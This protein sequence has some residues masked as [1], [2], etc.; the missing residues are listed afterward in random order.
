M[1]RVLPA[2]NQVPAILSET[3]SHLNT[4]ARGSGPVREIKFA[5][6]SLRVLRSAKSSGDGDGTAKCYEKP[7]RQLPACNGLAQPTTTRPRPRPP[8]SWSPSP[9]C[10]T[11]H[12]SGILPLWSSMRRQRSMASGLACY[13]TVGWARS[14]TPSLALCA[15]A[16][17][18]CRKACILWRDLSHEIANLHQVIIEFPLKTRYRSRN[19][20]EYL[21]LVGHIRGE[22][23]TLIS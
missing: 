22:Y 4:S 5:W 14:T 8:G 13:K 3:I 10:C 23:E 20:E 2:T 18:G 19:G 21:R 9:P 7:R 17:L 11:I 16:F 1:M 12:V 6:P 15:V